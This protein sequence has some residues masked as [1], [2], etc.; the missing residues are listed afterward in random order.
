M[1][2]GHWGSHIGLRALAFVLSIFERQLKTGFTVCVLIKV[3]YGV[4]QA[5]PG[6]NV[7]YGCHMP[8]VTL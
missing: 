8:K 3:K 4:A 1:S 5:S 7:N 6:D 2:Y